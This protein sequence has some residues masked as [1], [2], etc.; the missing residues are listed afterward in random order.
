MYLTRTAGIETHRTALQARQILLMYLTRTAGIETNI[1][2]SQAC[3]PN[4]CILPALRELKL[5]EMRLALDD[6]KMY[7]TRT[8]G[9][10]TLHSPCQGAALRMYLTRTAGIETLPP[11]KKK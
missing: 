7:L 2:G 10:E 6:I 5:T 1:R 9:I 3:A 4:E 8:A 11:A